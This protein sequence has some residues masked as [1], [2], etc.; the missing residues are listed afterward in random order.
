MNTQETSKHYEGVQSA[1][2]LG[3]TIKQV[4]Q[5]QEKRRQY[6]D[7]TVKLRR[8]KMLTKA[9][10]LL[11][12]T[13]SKPSK[14]GDNFEEMK[15]EFNEETQARSDLEGLDSTH[16]LYEELRRM[17]S[18]D[19]EV[20]ERNKKNQNKNRGKNNRYYGPKRLRSLALELSVPEWMVIPPASKIL[21][22]PSSDYEYRFK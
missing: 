16:P 9:R 1:K 22:F 4:F 21:I 20:N 15:E 19:T 2:P 13:Q 10:V 11:L 12:E 8:E 14:Q 6:L 7:E 3:E 17:E 5:F 18:E